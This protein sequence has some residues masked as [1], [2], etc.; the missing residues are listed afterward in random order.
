MRARRAGRPQTDQPRTRA[1]APVP[2]APAPVAAA[3]PAYSP[4]RQPAASKPEPAP[5]EPTDVTPIA[6]ANKR[7]AML[8]GTGAVFAAA[9]ATGTVYFA[10]HT[11]DRGGN[12]PA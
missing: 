7:R 10:L 1:H 2:A 9:A 3:Q 8:L 4:A 6:A 5:A 12:A 11:T